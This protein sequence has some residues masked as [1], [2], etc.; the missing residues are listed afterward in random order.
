MGIRLTRLTVLG[1]KSFADPVELVFDRGLTAIVGPNGSGKSNLADAIAWVLGEQSG[2]A[3]R[4]R[5][6]EEV[7]FA[8]GP[9]RAA[10]GMAEVTL[11]L[12]Q[13]AE[14]LGFPF[15]EVRL[16]RR[17]F[18]DGEN[19]YLINGARARLRDVAQIAAALRAEWVIVRQGAVDEV[20]DQRPNE[21]RGFLEHA[22]GLATLR[23]RQ[24]EARQRLTEAEQHAQRLED[25]LREL[26]PHIATLAEAAERA[27]EALTVREALRETTLHLFAARRRRARDE[28]ERARCRA[29]ECECAYEDAVGTVRH[30]RESLER[31]E[32]EYRA[33]AAQR[34]MLVERRRVRVREAEAAAHR[35]QVARERAAVLTLQLDSLDR[36]TVS[37]HHEAVALQQEFERV[38]ALHAATNNELAAV[39]S[40]LQRTETAVAERASRAAQLRRDLKELERQLTQCE[41]ERQRLARE[42]VTLAATTEARRQELAQLRAAA[43]ERARE[44]TAAE[45]ELVTRTAREAELAEQLTDAKLEVERCSAL[46]RQTG[47]KLERQAHVVRELE[48][49]LIL[50]R[51]RLDA[52]SRALEGEL[53]AGATRAV[54]AAAHRGQLSGVLGT[55][56]ALIDVPPELELAVE[57]ALGGHLHDVVVE[58]WTDAEAAIAFLK[59]HRAGRVTF[60]PLDSV[61]T[62]PP[63]RLPLAIG[64]PG[65]IGVA[66]ELVSASSALRP[67]VQ[68]LL[69]RVLVVTDLA[70]TRR[71]LQQLP[72]G[73]V[74][75]TREGELARPSGSVTGGAAKSRERGV[76][77]LARERRELAARSERLEQLVAQGRQEL[78]STRVEDEQARTTADEA[79]RKLR[80]LETAHAELLAERQRAER[81][82]TMLVEMQARET[83]AIA[84]LE[85]LL[86]KAEEQ[87]RALAA[88]EAEWEST[89]HKIEEQRARL[90]DELAALERADPERERLAARVAV[91][92]E[93][94]HAL[95]RERAQLERQLERLQQRA[96][97][98][99]SRRAQLAADYERALAEAERA[100]SEAA[101]LSAAVSE[102]EREE[103]AVAT[104]LEEQARCLSAARSALA[105]AEEHLRQTER[106]RAAVRAT[107]ERAEELQQA[108]LESAAWELSGAREVEELSETLAQLA[109]QVSEP[110]ERLERRIMDL[111][112]RWQELS[113][114]G[115]AAISQYKAER[116]RYESLR[117]ELQDVR[118]TVQTLRTLLAELDRQIERS[119][120]RSLRTL[121]RAF[122]ATFSEL[123]G[124]GRARLIARDGTGSIEGVEL[125]VQ[126]A[127]KRVRSVQQLS[128]GERALT[129]VALRFALL[130]SSPLPFCVLDEV[131]AALDEANVLRFRAMLARL[132]ERTQF[133]VITHNRATIEA[134]GTLYGVTMGED[135][136][137]RVVSLRLAE[138]ASE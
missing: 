138:Y 25:L 30:A 106:E 52:S 64:G 92:R 23:L 61:R 15:H 135:G 10:L 68:S 80:A 113:R 47:S 33:L 40:A 117:S 14:E 101:S 8:G 31:A 41:R 34:E 17:V 39:E 104:A 28:A 127:G 5:R 131:D 4:S 36:D 51:A 55:L 13:D 90:V 76:L 27:R 120:A 57:A 50:A 130:E 83:Q 21:R 85:R 112:R 9:G 54:L 108:V 137:S 89:H 91:L 123:F 82:L 24:A 20:L 63:T 122:A 79:H 124:G 96:S 111:R 102:F 97:E 77:S 94:T 110:P 71:L 133:L 26:E 74:I 86:T 134:A 37:T 109:E 56:G 121:D 6:A 32:S 59:E 95:E 18:R 132:A 100:E 45:R 99:A 22:A 66:A 62:F 49:E 42:R 60:H 129:A 115:E 35:A 75:V 73:W 69:G 48:R 88:Q 53:I 19:Q 93:R 7:I 11:V 136:A 126:P 29:A 70:T 118:A 81:A 2:A 3:M 128:G 119:F 43:V 72:P 116:A 65:V 16:T 105:T 125:V 98:L 38:A 107:L 78:E 46:L 103:V 1:F 84:H 44:R 114:F 67:V 58:R 87:E 12:E